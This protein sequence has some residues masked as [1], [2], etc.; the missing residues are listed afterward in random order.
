MKIEET[1]S[2]LY[3]NEVNRTSTVHQKVFQNSP[4]ENGHDP[5][6]RSIQFEWHEGIGK[7]YVKVI[8]KETKEIVREIPP[9]KMLDMYAMM[10]EYFGLFIDQKV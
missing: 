10:S 3:A 5:S 8:D 2:K 4:E 6:W 9:E 7:Y 1:S